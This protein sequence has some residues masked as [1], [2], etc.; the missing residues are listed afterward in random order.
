MMYMYQ[1]E[2][3]FS[4]SGMLYF[5]MV[6]QGIV[7]LAS[8]TYLLRKDGQTNAAEYYEELNKGFIDYWM[9]NA[10][11]KDLHYTVHGMFC[12]EVVTRS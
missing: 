5:H 8:F 12:I 4:T 11:V 10:L 3:I 1:L 2:S 9:K 7:A 6:L